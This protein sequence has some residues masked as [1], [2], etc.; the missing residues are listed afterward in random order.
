MRGSETKSSCL[1]GEKARARES[2]AYR[3]PR[4]RT[5][6]CGGCGASSLVI[7]AGTRDLP[8]LVF[9]SHNARTGAHTPASTHAHAHTCTGTRTPVL[10]CF[11]AAEPGVACR[12]VTRKGSR[13]DGNRNRR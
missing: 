13:S 4:R 11:A 12:I 6:V 2:V 10:V 1:A 5:P 9:S 7:L 8:F 3:C